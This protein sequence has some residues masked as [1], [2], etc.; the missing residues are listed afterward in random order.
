MLRY[1]GIAISS[2]AAGIRQAISQSFGAISTSCGRGIGRS[3][4]RAPIA[5][6]TVYC[7]PEA[8]GPKPRRLGVHSLPGARFTSAIPVRRDGRAGKLGGVWLQNVERRRADIHEGSS[9]FSYWLYRLPGM[10]LAGVTGL[11]WSP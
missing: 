5:E 6:N 9:L 11:E 2:G 4:R 8:Y 1:F 7:L 3:I 10:R